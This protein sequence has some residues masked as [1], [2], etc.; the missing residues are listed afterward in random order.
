VGQSLIKPRDALDSTDSK[1]L[2]VTNDFKQ[3]LIDLSNEVIDA[4][5]KTEDML[6]AAG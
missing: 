3:V 4:A 1:A 5:N 2:K 6:E